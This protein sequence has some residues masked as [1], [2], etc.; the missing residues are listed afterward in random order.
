MENKK[1]LKA[2][3]LLFNDSYARRADFSEVNGI[4]KYPLSFSTTRWL[5]N[6]AAAQRLLELWPAIVAVIGHWKRRVPSKRPKC[7]SYIT[8]LEAVDDK[9]ITAKMSF[10]AFVSGI[11]EPY[12]TKYQSE[13]PMVPY[14]YGDLLSLV[15][16]LLSLIIKEG[17]LASVASL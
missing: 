10:F 11:L 6:K 4:S 15:K 16:R 5:N 13:D 17:P 2:A 3:Y 14:M 1:V 9:L 8:L 12:L 7:T